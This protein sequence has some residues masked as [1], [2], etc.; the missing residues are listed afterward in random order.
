MT[1]SRPLVLSF[2]SGAL[3]LDL[4]LER[5]GLAPTLCVELDRWCCDT[6][7]A[8]RP[9][10]TLLEQDV[11]SFS[12]K[13]VRED[14][15][16]RS[17]VFLVTGGPPCQSF[18]TAGNRAALTDPRG[19]LIYEYLRIISEVRP[20]FFVLENVANITTAALRH[21]AIKD[22][23]GEHWSLK[24]YSG[25]QAVEVG[26]APL[27]PDELAGSAIRQ[28]LRDVGDLGY[29]VTFGVLDAADYGASQ[30]RMRFVM[31][32]SRE[33]A[34]PALPRPTHGP[35][36]GKPFATVRQAIEDIQ[37]RPGAHSI[38]TPDVA[39]FFDLVPEGGNW[40]SLPK[41]L[42]KKALGNSFHSG[43]GKTGFFRRLAWD[44]PSPTITGKANRKGTSICHP[45]Y[46][47]PLSV[48]ECARVQGFP[49]D[50]DFSGAMNRQYLQ[51]GNA[52]PVHLGEA[53]GRAILDARTSNT[54]DVDIM[55]DAA[56]RRIRAAASNKKSAPRTLDLFDM[57]A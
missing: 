17:D 20:R 8:N 21:R 41:D 23:P 16:L 48:R 32:G 50:W 25:K 7:R 43:G 12:W 36:A 15:K 26:K 6:I 52:V 37:N 38:Y 45:A 10:V 28:I 3:G 24:K 57:V 33:G 9:D 1:K 46:T 30:K 42:Q 51:V 35:I 54:Y 27:E 13:Q 11:R 56:V 5:A 34:A 2:F 4:G 22:R 55:L 31:I 47:R 53:I 40:R 18:S 44:A 19:N 14:Q 39:R 49:D 29:S